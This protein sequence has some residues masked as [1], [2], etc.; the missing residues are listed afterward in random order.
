[1]ASN[2]TRTSK[3]T[4][5]YVSVM[6][7]VNGAWKQAE[8]EVQVEYGSSK[9][10]VEKAFAAAGKVLEINRTEVRE[11]LREMSPQEW[12]KYSHVVPGGRKVYPS[13]VKREEERKAKE[14]AKASN[15]AR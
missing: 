7:K 10:E 1:M 11:E 9:S 3:Y 4:V 14:Q 12:L 13:M 5:Y 15:K 2:I 8:K 6:E